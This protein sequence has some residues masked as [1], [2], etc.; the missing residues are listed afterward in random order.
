MTEKG[1]VLQW[2]RTCSSGT[3]A[4]IIGSDR[5]AAIDRALSKAILYAASLDESA[6]ERITDMADYT[7]LILRA[8]KE[9][10]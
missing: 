10:S 2:L 1:R 5:Y 6:C 8:Q 7:A 4:D 3:A 9:V